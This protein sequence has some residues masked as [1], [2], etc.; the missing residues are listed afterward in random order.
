MIQEWGSWENTTHCHAEWQI[1]AAALRHF[2]VFCAQFLAIS[3][4]LGA[5]TSTPTT[6]NDMPCPSFPW[7]FGVSLVFFL[8]AISLVFWR[9]SVYFP[10]DAVDHDKAQKS[11]I[12]WRHLHWMFLNFLQWIFLPFLQVYSAI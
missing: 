1:G 5:A 8:L 3:P 4:S 10:Q 7:C 12:S 6:A 11:A 2:H 9:F